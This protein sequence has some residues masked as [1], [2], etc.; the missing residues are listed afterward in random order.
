V[1]YTIP[2]YTSTIAEQRYTY[3]DPQVKKLHE[4]LAPYIDR[5]KL[6]QLA[7]QSAD[8]TGALL[9]DDP[10]AEVLHLINLLSA[11]LYPQKRDKI[12]TPAD[13]AAILMV[14]MSH[15]DQEQ[16]RTVMLDTKNQLLGIETVYRGSLNASMIRVVLQREVCQGI[17]G[18]GCCLGGRPG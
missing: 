4:A 1:Y 16:F 9:S 7:A 11:L 17:A 18:A 6:R 13:A 5:R 15:L 14:E 2:S 10:P 12:R 8:L 3:A